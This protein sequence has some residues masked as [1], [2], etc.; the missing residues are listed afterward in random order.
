MAN[1]K[2]ANFGK[3]SKGLTLLFGQ[4][5]KMANFGKIS[6]GLTLLFE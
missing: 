3:I 6:K 5:L 4:N 1:L 2:M